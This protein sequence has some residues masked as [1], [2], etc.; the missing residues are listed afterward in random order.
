[1]SPHAT[2]TTNA[3]TSEGLARG[4]PMLTAAT[5]LAA[6][7]AWTT[8]AVPAR[9]D[10]TA[11]AN[12]A[13]TWIETHQNPD[14]S[15]GVEPEIRPLVTSEA[16]V[17]LRAAGRP[18]AAYLRGIA[19]L[20]NREM[21]SVDSQARRLV[22]L[23]PHGDTVTRDSETLDGSFSTDGFQGS[24]GTLGSGW[25]LAESYGPSALDTALAVRAFGALG[26][27]PPTKLV[28]GAAF[29]AL[30]QAE[31]TDLGWQ[32]VI[33]ADNPAGDPVTTAV[34]LRS[35]A[36][37]SGSVSGLQG[38]GDAAAAFLQSAVGPSSSPLQQAHAALALLRWTPGT[39][40]ADAWLGDLEG[41][42][43]PAGSWG[44]GDPYAT[45]VAL[46]AFSARLGTDDPV[47]QEKVVIPDLG[48]RTALNLALGKNR[49]DAIT[50]GEMQTLTDLDATG[51]GIEDLTGIEEATGLERIVLVGNDI[52]DLSPLDG[53]PN[54]TEVVLAL[55]CDPTGDGGVDSTDGLFALRALQLGTALGPAD[56]QAVDVAPPGAPD[57]ELTAGDVVLILRAAAGH[58]VTACG[59]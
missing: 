9:A 29:L 39:T 14:G 41:S 44:G 6:V 22:A 55:A 28:D 50:R 8:W 17:S 47:L 16:V 5:L 43:A 32:P 49:V 2:G 56:L 52:A 57:G 20:E 31:G 18:N 40:G 42:Q 58:A 12:A 26:G 11:V 27:T 23:L 19:W 1:M 34:V 15:W 33:G 51:Q 30:A 36:S 48:L 35:L 46:Q 4:N 37:V 3:T 53:L 54:L 13:A 59:T 21:T 24:G 38:V 25:G 7:L 10:F 45:A